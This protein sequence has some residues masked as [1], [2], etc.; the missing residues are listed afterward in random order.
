MKKTYRSFSLD[1]FIYFLYI[2]VPVL[3]VIT[4]LY[5]AYFHFLADY[6]VSKTKNDIIFIT[7]NIRNNYGTSNFRSFDTATIMSGSYLPYELEPQTVD[8]VTYIPNRFGG[9]MYFYEAFKTR[10]ERSL[11]FSLYRDP[12]KY[13]K[14]YPGVGAYVILLTNLNSSECRKLAQVDWKKDNSNYMGIEAAFL[15]PDDLGNGLYNLRTHILEDNFEEQHHTK[16]KGLT[17][18]I[19]FTHKKARKACGCTWRSCTIALK[20][21]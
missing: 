6:R 16:D 11:F 17:S 9:R 20:F 12:E 10:V 15:T 5:F 21:Y 13:Q 1:A 2:F 14:V 19:P 3:L 18:R 4:G 8:G 7:Q